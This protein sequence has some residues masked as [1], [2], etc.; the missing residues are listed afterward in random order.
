M[1][2]YVLWKINDW[3][4]FLLFYVLVFFCR[5]NLNLNVF[6]CKLEC[7]FFFNFIYIIFFVNLVNFIYVWFIDIKL[8]MWYVKLIFLFL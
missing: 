8:I 4:V 5:K 1:K 3:I 7:W 2:D 6:V